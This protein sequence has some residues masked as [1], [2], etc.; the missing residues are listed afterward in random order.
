MVTGDVTGVSRLRGGWT[1]PFFSPSLE[2]GSVSTLSCL[3]SRPRV[4]PHPPPSYPSS[5]GRDSSPEFHAKEST[6]KRDGSEMAEA[7][8]GTKKFPFSCLSCYPAWMK[9]TEGRI[10]EIERTKI[11]SRFEFLGTGDVVYFI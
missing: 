6:Q 9:M 8:P 4:S 5:G 10:G 1:N 3:V 7:E 2:E 11:A